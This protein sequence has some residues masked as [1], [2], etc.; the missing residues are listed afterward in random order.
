MILIFPCKVP[1][2]QSRKH[3]EQDEKNCDPR[4]RAK[5]TPAYWI[6]QALNQHE[7]GQPTH[8]EHPKI[9]TTKEMTVFK[10]LAAPL[11]GNVIKPGAPRSSGDQKWGFYQRKSGKMDEDGDLTNK[12]LGKIEDCSQPNSSNSVGQIWGAISPNC[13]GIQHGD[14]AQTTSMA[15]FYVED[16][17]HQFQYALSR[18]SIFP[19]KNGEISLHFGGCFLSK[20]DHKTGNQMTP[21]LWWTNIAIEN[22]H[23][24]SGF[25]H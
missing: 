16:P 18:C 8:P 25:S 21:T 14:L 15:I 9:Y 11:P 10:V 20:H 19:E 22:G 13:Y 3:K 12:H 7:N 17:S 23:R 1:P 4:R 5:Q 24:N 6:Y 2:A